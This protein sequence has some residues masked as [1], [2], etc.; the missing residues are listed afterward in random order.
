[1]RRLP[2]LVVLAVLVFVI[3][4][5]VPVHKNGS[6][7]RVPGWE[8]FT[9]ALEIPAKDNPY[10]STNG[11]LMRASACTNFLMLLAVFLVVSRPGQKPASWLPVSFDVATFLNLWW[12]KGG[13]ISDLRIGYWLWLASFAL[14]AIALY[15]MRKQARA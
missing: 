2:P 13:E 8:A 7:T 5:F 3:A 4:W 14:M 11:I 1:M 12:L 10:L 6:N 9:L 15:L